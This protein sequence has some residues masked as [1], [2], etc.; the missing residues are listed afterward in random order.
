MLTAENLRQE[1]IS[2]WRGEGTGLSSIF[3]VTHNIEEAVEMATRIV[4]L[5]AKPGR[6]GLVLDNPVPYPRDTK[7]PE[8][9][10]LVS[11]IHESI[12]TTTLPDHPLEPVLPGQPVSRAQHAPAPRVAGETPARKP[13]G[14]FSSRTPSV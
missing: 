1:L 6:F 7:S 13:F 3:M 9:Q 8:F 4:V 2:L 11:L 14:F 5:F 10:R 12:T